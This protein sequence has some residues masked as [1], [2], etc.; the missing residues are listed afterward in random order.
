[1]TTNA[2]RHP[3]DT[4]GLWIAPD[5][6][7]LP[8]SKTTTRPSGTEKGAAIPQGPWVVSGSAGR[9]R[10]GGLHLCHGPEAHPKK[11]QSW[12]GGWRWGSGRLSVGNAKGSGR[13]REPEHWARGSSRSLQPRRHRPTCPG[14]MEH[15]LT[16]SRPPLGGSGGCL[17]NGGLNRQALG[18]PPLPDAR[19]VRV[20]PQPG[21]VGKNTMVKKTARCR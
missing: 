3:P 19:Y 5:Y 12:G 14:R 10:C 20:E 1:M 11:A 18:R 16:A 6:S 8:P 9:P 15:L 13:R 21:R 4:E 7:K 17:Q 2:H